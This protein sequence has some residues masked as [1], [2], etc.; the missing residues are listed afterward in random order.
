MLKAG[1]AMGQGDKNTGLEDIKEIIES[2]KKA[3]KEQR[4]VNQKTKHQLERAE[5]LLSDVSLNKEKYIQNFEVQH[6]QTGGV[7][8]SIGIS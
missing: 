8:V 4:I 7:V 5:D 1:L 6:R 2:N 3:I